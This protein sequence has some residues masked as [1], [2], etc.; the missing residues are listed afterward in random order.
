MSYKYKDF[1]NHP[2]TKEQSA[3]KSP[4]AV[5]AYHSGTEEGTGEIARKVKEAS[6]YIAH[7]LKK[8]VASTRVTPTHSKHLSGVRDYAKTAISIHGHA[9]QGTYAKQGKSYDRTRTIYVTGGNKDLANKVAGQLREDIGKFYHVETDLKH[10]PKHLQGKSQYNV[11]NKFE[12]KGV[13]VELPHKL[14]QNQM[15]KETVANTIN[16]VVEKEAPNYQKQHK[17]AA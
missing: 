2:G 9:R 1:V 7:N 16:G 4:I 11:V 15:H 8:R 5:L 12:N 17:Q 6:K 14:R 3:R 10:I 13:Q